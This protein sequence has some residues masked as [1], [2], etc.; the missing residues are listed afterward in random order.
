[1][2]SYD[3]LQ[4]LSLEKSIIF[5]LILLCT[6]CDDSSIEG[7]ES[8]PVEKISDSLYIEKYILSHGVYGGQTTKYFIT[9]FSEFRIHVGNCDEK[10]FFNVSIEGHK[11]KVDKHTRRNKKWRESVKMCTEYYP[12]SNK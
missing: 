3:L 10:E 6:S 7:Y 8:L 1:M 5:L 4:N 11:I 12:I 2:N 9:D